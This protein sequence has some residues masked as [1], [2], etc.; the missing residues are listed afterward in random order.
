MRD[1]IFHMTLEERLASIPHKYCSD[2]FGELD[3]IVEEHLD[4][5]LCSFFNRALEPFLSA[6]PAHT[7]QVDLL[8]VIAMAIH[9]YPSEQP[10]R[11][12][13][14]EL[15][16]KKSEIWSKTQ[17]LMSSL[18]SHNFHVN[19]RHRAILV[20]LVADHLVL[21]TFN[22][23]QQ[24]AFDAPLF[25]GALPHL[26]ASLYAFGMAA[27]NPYDSHWSQC[28]LVSIAVQT[29]MQTVLRDEW[30][31]VLNRLMDDR[32]NY[33]CHH[34]NGTKPCLSFMAEKEDS[35]CPHRAR[36]R[37]LEVFLTRSCK[38]RHFADTQF[39]KYALCSLT[40]AIEFKVDCWTKSGEDN[41]DENI[42][43]EKEQSIA[44]A[45]VGK[46]I[47]NDTTETERKEAIESDGTESKEISPLATNTTN[48]PPCVL[49]SLLIA[50][51]PLFYF[52]LPLSQQGEDATEEQSE[53][54]QHRD[55]LV[56]CG[57][58]LLHHGN[59]DIAFGASKLLAV[60]FSYGPE[61]IISDYAGAI[62]SS[63]KLAITN[64]LE[65]SSSNSNFHIDGLVA[66]I[67]TATPA[68]AEAFLQLLFSLNRSHTPRANLIDRLISVVATACPAAAKDK[69]SKI[70]QFLDNDTTTNQSKSQL[71]GGL[72]A[73]RRAH[74]FNR[75]NDEIDECV[76]KIISGDT[77]GWDLYLVARQALVSGNFGAAQAIYEEL[78]LLTTSDHNFLWLST[79]AK[80]AAAESCLLSEG[81][82]GIPN[83]SIQ[84]R[85]AA[86]TILSL[87]G[88]LG[89][90]KANFDF[91]LRI[92]NLRLDFLDIICTVRQLAS[93]MRL[94]NVGPQKFTR[95]SLHLKS[96]VKILNV[97]GSKFLSLYRQMGL[98]ICQQ[99][100]TA[101]R[102]MYA[103]C[104]FASHA[105]RSSFLDEIPEA[106]TGT[107]RKN[108]SQMVA[109]LHGDVSHPLTVLMKRLDAQVLQDMSSTVEPKIRAAALLQVIDGVL[110]VPIPYPRSFLR[111][112]PIQCATYR[113]FLDTD[114]TD[115]QVDN[116][117]DF[118]D[119][120]EVSAGT[121]I[122]F[123]ASGSIPE[124]L[125]ERADIPFYTILLWHTITFHPTLMKNNNNADQEK[126]DGENNVSVTTSD[127]RSNATSSVFTTK[128]GE[129]NPP[130]NVAVSL[131][132]KG[133]FFMQIECETI[134]MDPGLYTIDTRLGCRDIRG[135]EWELPVEIGPQHSIPIRVVSSSRSS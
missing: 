131:S 63:I 88:F 1:Y 25:E 5:T 67:C 110:K 128:V 40:D 59:Y 129:S 53:D 39:I 74:F 34:A 126:P 68:L 15:E 69:T 73:C 56:S 38:A 113:L 46:H 27:L 50:A 17:R 117:E 55:M 4:A 23:E 99:S 35:F 19:Y 14:T 98:F 118:D 72:L 96:S 104:R 106:S 3:S 71:L 49:S 81:A 12:T 13:I 123:L 101:V 119:V 22:K 122:S 111:T 9:P 62:F 86:S 45:S 64:A 60:A 82:H 100:R 135:G 57:I 112:K 109:K 11:A 65:Q 31:R 84:L 21:P 61:N 102:T 114:V 8:H 91:Q 87:P 26:R 52:L 33:A 108:A 44:T 48:E 28:G 121:F 18:V 58:Q 89:P 32:T 77:M 41:D 54:S 93:E 107:S 127:T 83:S 43:T 76:Q 133:R 47:T 29:G 130:P 79:L 51:T 80:I 115:D 20:K 125:V 103:L 7:Q 120:V 2:N 37:L 94:A 90:I 105:T 124:D 116:E 85:S 92:L 95:P 132:P 24:A 70:I 16:E 78:T 30:G 97:L 42:E 36:G 75:C 134:L 6:R 66:T 10:L